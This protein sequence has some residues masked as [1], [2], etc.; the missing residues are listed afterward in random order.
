MSDTPRTD[1]AENNSMCWV[2]ADFART[3]ERENFENQTRV[4]IYKLMVEDFKKEVAALQKRASES[5][6]NA[7]IILSNAHIRAEKAE[8]ERDKDISPCCQDWHTCQRR[9]APLAENWRMAAKQAEASNKRLVDALQPFA[10]FAEQWNKNPINRLHDT[11]YSIHSG[12]DAA[13]FR[14]SD[15]QKAAELL[16]EV[17]K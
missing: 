7:K 13:E 2:T 12:D 5:A 1:E 14:L 4:E 6:D 10:F 15:C 11:L 17:A 3:L 16:R 9:C 8:Q